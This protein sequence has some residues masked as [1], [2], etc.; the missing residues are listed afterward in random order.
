MKMMTE[1][2]RC[3]FIVNDIEDT[4]FESGPTGLY[5][6]VYISLRKRHI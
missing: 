2:G 5:W 4:P 3:M 1:Y 6:S